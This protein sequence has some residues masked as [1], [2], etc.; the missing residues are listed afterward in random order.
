[1]LPLRRYTVGNHQ[2]RC[3]RIFEGLT[4]SKISKS[5]SLLQ[6]QPLSRF[7]RLLHL[8]KSKVIVGCGGSRT[9]C[10]VHQQSLDFRSCGD[11]VLICLVISVKGSSGVR[12]HLPRRGCNCAGFCKGRGYNTENHPRWRNALSFLGQKRSD[13]GTF[14]HP[15]IARA[16][17]T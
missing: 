17:E 9:S 15:C 14:V 5:R 6:C 3:G 8:L 10:A 11:A 1:M 13:S 4:K 16:R 12:S 2:V 7:H